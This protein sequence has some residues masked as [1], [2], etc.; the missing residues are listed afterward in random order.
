MG[1][2]PPAVVTEQSPARNER[3]AWARQVEQAPRPRHE[4]ATGGSRPARSVAAAVACALLLGGCAQPADQQDPAERTSPTDS[5]PP[6][7][8]PSSA[9]EPAYST[10]ERGAHPLPLR[11]DGLGQIGPTPP[12]LRE[13]RYPTVDVLPPPADG[14]FHG[15]VEPVTPEIARRST[16]R[17]GCP[18]R[19]DAL[20]YVTVSFRG[21]DGGAHTGELLVAARAAS[22]VVSV[23]RALYAADFPIEEMRLPTIQDLEAHP[24]G[25]GNNTAAFVCR[26]TVGASASWSAHAYG[27]AI[28]VNPFMNPYSR[29]A[30]VLPELASSYLRRG[31]RRPG[32][33]GPDS[34]AVREFARIGW[35]WGGRW[36]GLKDYQH[37]TATGR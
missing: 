37:F 9:P 10:W 4:V 8:P 1:V 2:R 24:T 19:L 12:S 25:D 21:F 30:V 14:R 3:A 11:S 13:R 23:F 33:I 26:P 28:D 22:R 16:W 29:G 36:R 15:S 7:A 31:W 17:A 32:M 6:S 20:R 18:V 35:S 34:V 5:P 27:L